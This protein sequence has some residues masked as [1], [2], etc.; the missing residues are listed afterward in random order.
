M[1]KIF[2]S[3]RGKGDRGVDEKLLHYDGSSGSRLCG[4][5]LIDLPQGRDSWRAFLNA[6]MN[7]RVP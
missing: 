2:K 6:I 3:G 1:C 4:Y 7:F 5:G